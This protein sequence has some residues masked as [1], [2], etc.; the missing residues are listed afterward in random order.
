M[1]QSEACL[2]EQI[3]KID[4]KILRLQAQRWRVGARL[5]EVVSQRLAHERATGTVDHSWQKLR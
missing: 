2:R 1:H 3:Q 4:Q 5:D